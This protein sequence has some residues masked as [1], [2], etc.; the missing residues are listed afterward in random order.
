MIQEI[1]SVLNVTTANEARIM[2]RTTTSSSKQLPQ[3]D[4]S[5]PPSLTQ[6]AS[7]YSD[8]V[9]GSAA[10]LLAWAEGRQPLVACTVNQPS[11]RALRPTSQDRWQSRL[12]HGPPHSTLP[13]PLSPTPLATPGRW[14][15]R[16]WIFEQLQLYALVVSPESHGELPLSPQAQIDDTMDKYDAPPSQ[17]SQSSQHLTGSPHPHP[18]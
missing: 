14:Q 17:L 12:P 4:A 8:E 9:N 7:F 18:L 16:E 5:S 11:Y 13:L 1:A 6:G 15:S 10:E 2:Q 3:G